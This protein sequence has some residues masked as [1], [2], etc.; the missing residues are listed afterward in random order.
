MLPAAFEPFVK[1]APFCV[2]AR[3]ALES[4]FSSQRLDELF[5]RTAQKQY[6]RELLFS[7]LVELMTAVVL[8]QQPSVYAAYKKGVGSIS[9]SDQSVYNK[10][11]GMELAVSAALVHDSAERITAV[12]DA[13]G[14]RQ[15]SWLP[16]YRIR[17]L[18]V[19]AVQNH[20]DGEGFNLLEGGRDGFLPAMGVADDGNSHFLDL[21]GLHWPSPG[22]G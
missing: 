3:V 4:L 16:G 11:D 10:L 18:D 19:A 6:T 22:G 17:I 8:Q 15:P 9:V 14:V 13:L 20:V 7:Q 12:L 5:E 2:M 21:S 1:Q